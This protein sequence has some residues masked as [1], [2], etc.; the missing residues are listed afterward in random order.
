MPRTAVALGA[1]GA[2]NLSAVDTV[3]MHFM[4]VSLSTVFMAFVGAMLTLAFSD[5][6]TKMPKKKLYISMV[7]FTLMSTAGVAVFPSLLGWEW[8]NTK[9]EGS[10]AFLVAAVSPLAFPI[11]RTL[12]PEIVRKWFR[13][14]DAP[15]KHETTERTDENL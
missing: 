11:I 7:F 13:L 2:L 15:P 12:L 8:Y 6:T 3:P 14:G 9:L 5:E 10:L 4:N 1:L